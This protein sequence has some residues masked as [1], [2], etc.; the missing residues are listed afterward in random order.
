MIYL[1]DGY[2]DGLLTC[3]YDHYYL[4]KATEIYD[5]DMYQPRLFEDVKV[6]DTDKEKATKVYNAIIKKL[7]PQ[8]YWDIFNTFL[9]N[10]QYKDCY[11]LA[12]LVEAFK[13]GRDINLL[14]THKATINIKRLSRQVG[15]EKHRFL[16][17]LRFS[18][19]GECLY[20][21]IEPDHDILILIADHFANR[22]KNERLIIY[23]AKRKKAIIC[24][25]GKWVISEFI[26]EQ[27]I[28]LSEK[29]KHIQ[30]LWKGYFTS[31]GIE[32]R[33]NLKLQ[34]NF[35]PLK[36]RKNIVEFN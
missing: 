23:D 31:V 12:Y 27:E 8:S 6:I 26:M 24:K 4:K 32:S 16:G 30:S 21:K 20:S 35:V 29:E 7:S 17:L 18:D 22:L 19:I 28:E 11:I 5:R 2:F 33:K 3:I 9:S 10:N 25:Y 14:H 36:Y 1:H 34:Q 13:L 15:F